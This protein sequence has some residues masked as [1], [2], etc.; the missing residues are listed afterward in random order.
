MGWALD[1]EPAI[2]PILRHL[3]PTNPLLVVL[4][5]DMHTCYI[6]MALCMIYGSYQSPSSAFYRAGVL[7]QHAA[8]GWF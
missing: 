5:K 4:E 6:T 1:V 8:S 7:A 2:T 3:E